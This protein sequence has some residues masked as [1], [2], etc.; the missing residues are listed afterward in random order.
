MDYEYSGF[1]LSNLW[2]EVILAHPSGV[3]LDEVYYDNGDTF[4]DESGK[5]MMLMDP[6][7]DN[8][9]GDR[10]MVADVVYGAGDYG[11]PPKSVSV[12]AM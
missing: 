2:D 1:T 8:S 5:S 12:P 6:N 4:P 11:T 3:I 10:W 7:L 9:L